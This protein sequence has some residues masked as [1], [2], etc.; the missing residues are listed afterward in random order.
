MNFSFEH[1]L[2]KCP[3]ELFDRIKN[4]KNIPQRADYHPEG[5]VLNHTRIVVNRLSKYRDITLSW[6]GMFHD[7]GKDETTE[8][9]DGIYQSPGYEL[10]SLDLVRKYI[11]L[12]DAQ[13]CYWDAIA[14]I[15]EYH[16]RIKLMDE[17]SMAK[18][19]E[20]RHLKTFGLL[21]LFAMADDMSTLTPGEIKIQ[22]PK[23][24]VFERNGE[25]IFYDNIGEGLYITKGNTH[26]F[27]ITEFDENGCYDGMKC[28]NYPAAIIDRLKEEA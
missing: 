5:N 20:M 16:M 8:L 21:Q 23:R 14:E 12:C 24:L 10:V 2:A 4:L 15:V 7:I 11:H 28:L 3:K 25:K 26:A 19:L 18:Q 1:L 22:Y 27:S 9:K 17:M 13:E 6:A